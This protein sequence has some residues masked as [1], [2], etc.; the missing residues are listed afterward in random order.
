L[1]RT[2][3]A[4][5][6]WVAKLMSGEPQRRCLACNTCVNEMRGGTQLHCV[7]NAA[8][9]EE[10]PF[11]AAKPPQGERIAIIGAGPPGA[12]FSAPPPG[13][14]QGAVRLRE[15]NTRAPRRP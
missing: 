12:P 11:A 13:G 6:D 15:K 1:G 9:G 2:L 10:T 8:A 7:V 14:H 4:E 3:I 5:P